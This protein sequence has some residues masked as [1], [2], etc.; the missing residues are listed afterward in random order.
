[1]RL[2]DADELKKNKPE[3]YID[4]TRVYFQYEID[5]AT[6]VNFMI[7]PDYVTELQ[8][9]NK[10][11]IKQLEET[12]R[13]QGEWITDINHCYSDDEDTFECSVCKE[14]FT[15]IYGTP[16]DNLYNF[17]PNCGAKMITYTGKD[18]E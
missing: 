11:L 4:G 1:M 15:L 9:L 12:E 13:L 18:R 14:P 2:I 5:N 17:C 16:K 6:T 3:E 10:E 8:N 7:S